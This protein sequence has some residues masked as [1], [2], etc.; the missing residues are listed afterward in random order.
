MKNDLVIEQ[1]TQIADLLEILDESVYKIRAY[2]KA[3]DTLKQTAEDIEVI[4]KEN[5][6]TKLSGVGDALGEKIKEIVLYGRTNYLDKLTKEIPVEVTSLMKVEGI[7]GKT[8]G[9]LYRELGIRSIDGLE[10]AIEAGLLEELSGFTK[11]KIEKIQKAMKFVKSERKPL[12]E[13]LPIAL[14]LKKYLQTID[15]IENIE[16]GG[17]IRRRKSTIRDIDLHATAKEEYFEEIMSLFSKMDEVEDIIVTGELKTTVKLVNGINVDLR[18]VEPLSDGSGLIHATGSRNHTVKLR[19]IAERNGFQLNEYGYYE[20]DSNKLLASTTEEEVYEAMGMSI[21]PPELREDRGEIEAALNNSLPNLIKA[22]DVKADFHLHTIWSDG[23]SA[24]D[25]Y[26]VEAK[27]LEYEYVIVTDHFGKNPIYNP[28]NK[29]KLLKQRKAIEQ[30]SKSSEFEILHGVECDILKDGSL[31]ITNDL[32]KDLD[33]VIASIH[34]LFDMS[35]EDM[36]SRITK[37]MENEYVNAIGHP[38]GRQ[39]GKR[40][41]YSINFSEIIEKGIETRTYLEINSYPNRLDVDDTVVFDFK[42]R[43]E[44]YIGTD[45]HSHP[46]LINYGYGLNIARRAWCEKKNI[47]NTLSSKDLRKKLNKK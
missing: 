35:E 47:L 42:D 33:F 46:Q 14:K 18:I 39:L 30:I 13:V 4:V 9:R 36:T 8:A 37:A 10:Q 31:S 5:R 41:G 23:K 29:E 45:S 40:G 19:T 22:S 2:R 1:L 27:K 15:L 32:L 43:I 6:V 16:I 3:V 25:D 17:S 44:F 7:G 28:L 11:N 21:I 34:S 12:F 24:I 26:I 20:K 38:T